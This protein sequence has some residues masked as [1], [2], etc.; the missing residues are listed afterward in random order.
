MKR[1]PGISVRLPEGT[2]INRATTFNK[3]SVEKFFNNL[4]PFL[5]IDSS[6]IYNVDETGISTFARLSKILAK[7]GKARVAVATSGERGTNTTVICC[8]SAT[9][10]FVPP[11]FI[12]KR[13]RM[14]EH[15]INDAPVG[16]IGDCSESGWV[17]EDLY[18]KWLI[19]SKNFT[20]YSPENPVLLIAENYS[21]HISLKIFYFLRTNGIKF[22]TIPPHTS[23]RLQPLDVSFFKPLK[24]NYAENVCLW[25]MQNSGKVVTPSRVAGIFSK[26]YLSICRMKL[27]VSGFAA[28]GI[29]PFNRNIFTPEDF[30]ADNENPQRNESIENIHEATGLCL[31]LAK[32][33]VV[34]RLQHSLFRQV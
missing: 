33:P 7:R 27:A 29:F 10:S 4:E 8:M 19:H 17:N 6:R 22:V 21:S 3:I 12:F 5:A 23:H 26:A 32:L 28:T 14:A 24:I 9:G 25:L 18:G 13:L 11:M 34:P 20:K 16:S 1:H 30:I 15:L 2:S 31:T